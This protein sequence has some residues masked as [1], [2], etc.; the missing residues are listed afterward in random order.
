M[1]ANND[2]SVIFSA[3]SLRQFTTEVFEYFNVPHEDAVLAADV[4]AKLN[5]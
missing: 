3:N 5:T 4:L 1:P 2:H